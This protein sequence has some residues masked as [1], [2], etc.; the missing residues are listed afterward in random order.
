MKIERIIEQTRRDFRAIYK[1]EHCGYSSEENGYDDLNFHQNVIP[2]MKC[3]RCG[4]KSPK[5]SRALTTKYPS[6]MQL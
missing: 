4:E 2:A 6:D 3:G 5:E 1:C